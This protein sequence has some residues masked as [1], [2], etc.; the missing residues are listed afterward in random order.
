MKL[1]ASSIW[2][3]IW[4]K[5]NLLLNRERSVVEWEEKKKRHRKAL[6]HILWFNHF[7]AGSL[8]LI[9]SFNAIC[10]WKN[11]HNHKDDWILWILFPQHFFSNNF[12]RNSWAH[13]WKRRHI[14]YMNATYAK[15]SIHPVVKNEKRQYFF[16]H[17]KIVLD[18][19]E[20]IFSGKKTLW[21]TSVNLKQWNSWLCL[22]KPISFSLIRQRYRN[23]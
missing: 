9:R 10:S 22:K 3:E 23:Y 17:G 4:Q 18:D 8:F 1:K 7:G 11:N 20:K 16:F 21:I 5:E 14:I 19:K 6:T 12:W 13:N 15:Q 2:C